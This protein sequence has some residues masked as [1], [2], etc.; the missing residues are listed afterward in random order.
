V[1][2]LAARLEDHGFRRLVFGRARPVFGRE[3]H[4]F[5]QGFAWVLAKVA[6]GVPAEEITRLAYY[7]PERVAEDEAW[8]AEC[9]RRRAA[10]ADG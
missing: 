10:Q 3:P 7:G 6:T 1:P 9:A 5:C 4:H 8:T 2:E